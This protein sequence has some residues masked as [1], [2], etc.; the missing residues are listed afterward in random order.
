LRN[1][2][3]DLASASCSP[4]DLVTCPS[5][6]KIAMLRHAALL[7]LYKRKPPIADL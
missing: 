7:L 2:M 5:S 6:R 4:S 3:L 1:L